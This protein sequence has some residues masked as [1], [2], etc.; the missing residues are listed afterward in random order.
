MN[1][2]RIRRAQQASGSSGWNDS[3]GSLPADVIANA[4]LRLSTF[5]KLVAG[6]ALAYGIV[7]IWDEMTGHLQIIRAITIV[8]VAVYSLVLGFAMRRITLAGWQVY[9]VGVI[10]LLSMA[11]MVSLTRHSLPGGELRGWSA[12]T[13]LALLFPVL[14]PCSPRRASLAA[15][16]VLI[17]ALV[18]F[19]LTRLLGQ[20]LLWSTDT[21]RIFMGEILAIP[22]AGFVSSVVYGLGRELASARRLGAYALDERLGQGGMGE[23]W[24]G[25]HSLLARPAAIKLIRTDA[26]ENTTR[27]LRL[28]LLKRFEREAQATAVLKCPHT[29]S[30]FDFGISDEGT[31]YYVMELLDGI[32]LHDMVAR[33]GALPPA[34]VLE[35]LKQACR[36]LSEAHGHGMV[37][38]DIKP[39]NIVVCQLGEEVDFVKVLDFG[40]V[41]P[42]HVPPSDGRLTS[43]G[44]IAGTPAF[45]SPEQGRGDV[46][47]DGR[48]DLY[49]LGC[50]AYWLLTG[51]LVFEGSPM[52]MIASHIKEEPR[53]V[54][55]ATLTPIPEDL[56]RVVMQCL[57]KDP[58]DRPPSA[59]AI[60]HALEDIDL[61]Q[62]WTQ[63]DARTW[64][65]T[66]IAQIRVAGDAASTLP[67][68]SH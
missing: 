14:V 11:F 51:Q 8:V 35:I 67:L 4:S 61:A 39:S 64:W 26:M 41:T 3:T 16:G 31:F 5:A 10:Y 20:P 19:G 36:S 18:A 44:E 17:V 48:S 13:I 60:L 15:T 9:V 24:R 56:E 6:I 23:V 42:S 47:I 34:R 29:V 55:I 12:A 25:H 58:S 27:E 21:A 57:E 43:M 59:R 7:E 22:I 54:S 65:S 1:A 68:P 30:V 38:R 45:I 63:Q 32:D 49:A 28:E 46:D 62:T 40:L 66:H 33:Y 37:H 2:V 50:V 52:E 53:P